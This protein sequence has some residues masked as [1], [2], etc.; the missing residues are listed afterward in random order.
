[1]ADPSLPPQRRHRKRLSKRIISLDE[2]RLP[3]PEREA[4]L[5]T[6]APDT[7]FINAAGS[8]G[9]GTRW[10]PYYGIHCCSAWREGPDGTI[11]F[12]QH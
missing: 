10:R 1:M 8:S 11:A 4:R 5:L 7:T 2:R 3:H 12:A 6:P 9:E